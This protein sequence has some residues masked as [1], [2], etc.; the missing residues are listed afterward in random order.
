MILEEVQAMIAHDNFKY[1][2]KG[3]KE[4]KKSNQGFLEINP[5]YMDQAR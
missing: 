1:P 5:I 2:F 4:V 3:M